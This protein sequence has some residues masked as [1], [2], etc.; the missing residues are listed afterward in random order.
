[1]TCSP[2]V[3]VLGAGPAAV[4]AACALNRLGHRVLLIGTPGNGAVEGV[5]ER[6]LTL[7]REIGLT[8][9]ADVV[10]GPGERLGRWADREIKGT[11]ERLA[12]RGEFDHALLKDARSRGVAALTRRVVAYERLGAGWRV[13]TSG[14][15]VHCR[16]IIDARGRRT[17]RLSRKGPDLIAICQRLR[18]RDKGRALTRIEATPQGWCWLALDGRG[19]GWLQAIS[20]PEEQSL[21]SG[22]EQHLSGFLAAASQ[23]TAELSHAVREGAPMARAATASLSVPHSMPGILRAGDAAI[24]LDPLSGQ[25]MYEA[26]RSAAVIAAAAHS[27]LL[28]CDWELVARF[29]NERARELWRQKCGI[30]GLFYEQ[31]AAQISSPFWIAS[32]AAYAATQSDQAAVPLDRPRIE[33]RPILNGALIQPRLVVVTAQHPRGLWTIND[34]DLVKLVE[35]LREARTT[36]VERA[37]Q[38]FSHSPSAIAQAMHWLC[39]NGLIPPVRG[40][41]LH[42]KPGYNGGGDL[43]FG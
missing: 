8:A 10:H 11:G 43:S 30:A 1:M 23:T 9:T 13:Q 38:H 5:S 36:S 16:A 37:A 28:G 14:G 33:C 19:A 40:G 3:T 7:L 22:L 12:H 29:V 24:A 27:F 32:A 42:R 18:T 34:V 26:L 15:T 2:E 6:T 4:A 20:S 41:G 35:F 39:E 31:Q 17:S 21:R 25:G